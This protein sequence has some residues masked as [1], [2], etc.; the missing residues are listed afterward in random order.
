MWST[1][2]LSKVSGKELLD[3]EDIKRKM[4][5]VS[6][7]V[8]LVILLMVVFV[9]DHVEGSGRLLMKKEI[10]V[11]HPETFNIGGG[12]F[13]SSPGSFATGVGFGP[14]GLTF[15]SYPPARCTTLP[16]TLGNGAGGSPPHP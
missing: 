16:P 3:I 7:K 12:T 14:S 6:Y 15:C 4:E 13:P 2:F 1:I 9:S 5:R 8:V 11:D 10:N